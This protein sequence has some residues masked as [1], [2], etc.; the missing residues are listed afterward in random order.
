MGGSGSE[1]ERGRRSVISPNSRWRGLQERDAL[2]SVTCKEEPILTSREG[3]DDRHRTA[4][5]RVHNRHWSEGADELCG[6][7]ACPNYVINCCHPCIA[8]ASSW[9]L[10]RSKTFLN[11]IINEIEIQSTLASPTRNEVVMIK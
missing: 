9:F 11:R 4:A 8:G 5:A 2:H 10:K 6:N 1:N 7:T 3:L